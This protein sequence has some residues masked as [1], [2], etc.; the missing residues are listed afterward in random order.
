MN[1]HAK[2]LKGLFINKI[3][4]NFKGNPCPKAHSKVVH[5]HMFQIA[6]PYKSSS[7]RPCFEIHDKYNFPT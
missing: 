4:C 3:K 6:K 1:H 2:I 5:H 7:K